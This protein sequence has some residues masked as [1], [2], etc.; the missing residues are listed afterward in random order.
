MTE[1]D[2]ILQSI[3]APSTSGKQPIAGPI[4]QLGSDP[5]ATFATAFELL[6]GKILSRAELDTQLQRPRW[7]DPVLD[8]TNT[9]ASVWDAELGISRADFAVAKTGSLVMGSG[10]GQNRLTSLVP[11]TNV[12]MISRAAIV[13]TLSEALERMPMGNV[14]MIT[15]PSRTA[16][17]EGVMVRGVHGPGELLLFIEEA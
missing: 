14:V 9:A 2:R 1:R 5:W 13:Q 16:D 12:V 4:P 10:G 8:L 15:G 6:G 3:G 11:P 7:V 17:I